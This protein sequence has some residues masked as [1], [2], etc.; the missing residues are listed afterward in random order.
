MCLCVYIRGKRRYVDTKEVST[1]TF[2]QGIL[3]QACDT[4]SLITLFQQ[5]CFIV[6]PRYFDIVNNS[7]NKNIDQSMLSKSSII[8]HGIFL[9]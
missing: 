7:K 2:F 9:T 8:T 5:L 4:L 3:S 1:N 6:F